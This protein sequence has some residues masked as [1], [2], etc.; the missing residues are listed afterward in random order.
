M[1]LLACAC[2][3][4]LIG[5]LLLQLTLNAKYFSNITLFLA[6]KQEQ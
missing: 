3:F 6:E 1:T 2:S 5:S 4:S